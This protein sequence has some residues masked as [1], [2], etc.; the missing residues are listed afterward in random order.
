MTATC[1]RA[2]CSVAEDLLEI[3]LGEQAQLAGL[4]R[5]PPGAHGDLL[6]RLLATDVKHIARRGQRR[7]RLQQ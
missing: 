7:K 6:T 3:D 1:G 4:Q 5:Q 2:V